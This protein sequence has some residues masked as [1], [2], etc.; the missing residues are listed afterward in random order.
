MIVLGQLALRVQSNLGA[1]PGKI[2]QAA[3]LL[4]TTF[5]SVDLHPIQ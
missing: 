5:D 3:D 4:E 2:E 1:H